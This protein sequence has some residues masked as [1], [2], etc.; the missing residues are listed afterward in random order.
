V[1]GKALLKVIGKIQHKVIGVLQPNQIGRKKPIAIGKILIQKIQLK[2]TGKKITKKI[3]SNLKLW[4]RKFK[5]I[6]KVV[7]H[8][9]KFLGRGL[10]LSH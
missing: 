1:I 7:L 8:W 9:I 5:I 3:L 6:P 2:V 10:N 4:G